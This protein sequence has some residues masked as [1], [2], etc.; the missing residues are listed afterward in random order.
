MLIIAVLGHK[1]QNV[2]RQLFSKIF[3]EHT[4]IIA[5]DHIIMVDLPVLIAIC[6]IETNQMMKL[7]CSL[8]DINFFFLHHNAPKT[9]LHTCA[10]LVITC[11][12]IITMV[13]LLF[14]NG[15]TKYHVLVPQT[16]RINQ[17]DV[18][19]QLDFIDFIW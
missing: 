7:P 18:F 10:E 17:L 8:V 19:Y 3:K 9:T 11:Y 15:D 6:V 4:I 16:G 2:H 13:S 12:Y 5:L 14:Q 1:Q